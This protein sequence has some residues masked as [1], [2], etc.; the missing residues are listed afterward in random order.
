MPSQGHLSSSY[1]SF[2]KLIN[3][4]S[5]VPC[6]KLPAAFFPED[7]VDPKLRSASTKMAKALCKSCPIIEACFTYALETNQRYGV[8]GGTS[9]DER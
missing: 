8:W 5:G 3:K 2:L 1:M 4:Q 9:A 7:I 6:E